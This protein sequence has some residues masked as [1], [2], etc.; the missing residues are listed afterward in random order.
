MD[1]VKIDG[2]P[3]DVI[4]VDLS[5]NFEILYT[6]NTGRTMAAGAKMFL[7]PIGTFYGHK[8]TFQRKN[9]KEAEYDFLFDFLSVPRADGLLFEV[10]HGQKTIRYMAYVSKGERELRRIDDKTGKVYWGQFSINIVPMEA[11]LTP[12]VE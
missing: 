10:V 5:E 2:R 11:W 4:V 12:D 9:G 7:E 1:W 8:I 3:F 6:E